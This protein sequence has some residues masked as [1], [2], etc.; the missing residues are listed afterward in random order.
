MDCSMPG[1]PVLHISQSWLKLMSIEVVMPPN[2]LIPCH[3]L[4][5]LTMKLSPWQDL[6]P[7]LQPD[8]PSL[9]WLLPSS[10][11]VFFASLWTYLRSSWLSAVGHVTAFRP[12]LP[13]CF[14]LSFLLKWHLFREAFSLSAPCCISILAAC[15]ICHHIIYSRV[16]LC[17]PLPL[18]W[19]MGG[20]WWGL[21]LVHHCILSTPNSI[22]TWQV[23][24][25]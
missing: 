8:L 12:S 5:L 23:F 22:G 7:F 6:S 11:T 20:W 18:R 13:L 15:I 17:V 21:H 16:Y 9:S 1:F 14:S 4:L 19:M 24:R 3:P 25:Q 10:C 2:H